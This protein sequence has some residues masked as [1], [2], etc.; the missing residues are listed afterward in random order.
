MRQGIESPKVESKKIRH[1]V[2]EIDSGRAH[3]SVCFKSGSGQEQVFRIRQ[4]GFQIQFQVLD[5]QHTSWVIQ[6]N[7]L[8]PFP[9]L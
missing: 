7:K 8:S 4:M 3:H 5:L 1:A 2:E 9:E 6:V